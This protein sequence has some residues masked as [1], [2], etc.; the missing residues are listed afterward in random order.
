[1]QFSYV[2]I[3]ARDYKSLAAF[4][5][6]AL[7][8]EQSDKTEWLRG[9]EGVALSAP[10]FDKDNAPVFGIV[11]AEEGESGK[12]NDTG[13]AHIC[14]ETTDV[15]KAVKRLLKN[16]GSVL[17]T[18]KSPQNHPCVYCKDPAG[19]VVEFHIPFPSKGTAGECLTTAGSLLGLKPNRGKIKFIHVNIITEDWRKLCDFYNNVFESC[20]FGK[21]KDHSGSYK[22]KVISIPGVHVV[23][24]HVLLKGFYESYP[25]L[26]IFTYSVKGRKEATD[27]NAVGINCIGF[28]SGNIKADAEKILAAGGTVFEEKDSFILAGDLQNGRILLKGI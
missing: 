3:G 5:I 20:D 12:I 14:F 28:S 7:D 22:E 21:M 25:T 15:K 11:K 4:Y 16:G 6:E 13:F 26:E 2:Q 23:G 27:E 24:Q 17:S 1:M 18:M 10:G 19:N 8:F 9:K